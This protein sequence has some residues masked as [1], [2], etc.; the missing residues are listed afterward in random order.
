[1]WCC[2][3]ED[4]RKNGH[5]GTEEKRGGDLQWGK[6][7]KDSGLDSRKVEYENENSDSYTLCFHSFGSFVIIVIVVSLSSIQPTRCVY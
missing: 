6:E 4:K 5:R 1:M 2:G 3:L 7:E